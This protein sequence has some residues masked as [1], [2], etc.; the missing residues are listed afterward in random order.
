[1]KLVNES[2]S[3]AKRVFPVIG[4]VVFLASLIDSAE[5]VVYKWVDDDGKIHYGDRLATK[6]AKQLPFREPH[7][8][9][10]DDRSLMERLEKQKELL[11]IRQYERRIAKKR[12]EK[13]AKANREQRRHC[14]DLRDHLTKARQAGVVY[15]VDDSG[16][17]VYSADEAF[18]AYIGRLEGAYEKSCSGR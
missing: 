4:A 17:R 5:A 16:N 13:L 6:G 18:A 3:L 12:Q 7:S 9:A 8:A 15:E 1:M 10:A 2:S 11:D 14:T